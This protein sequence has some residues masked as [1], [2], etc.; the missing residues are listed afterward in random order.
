[1]DATLQLHDKGSYQV[2][3][4][5]GRLDLKSIHANSLVVRDLPLKNTVVDCTHIEFIDSSGLGMLTSLMQ[6]LQQQDYGMALLRVSDVISTVLERTRL[7][8]LFHFIDEEM[9][10]LNIFKQD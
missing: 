4:L 1:M 6:R 8:T 9:E 10:A 3:S 5:T 2:L 7:D